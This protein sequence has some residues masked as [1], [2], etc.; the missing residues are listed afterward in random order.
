M[1]NR[2]KDKKTK[3]VLF[4][5]FCDVI[6]VDSE[7]V[8]ILRTAIETLD[9]LSK[10]FPLASE[11][12]TII[13]GV[14]DTEVNIFTIL[15]NSPPTTLVNQRNSSKLF[16]NFALQGEMK[17]VTWVKFS[18]ILGCFCWNFQVPVSFHRKG[19]RYQLLLNRIKNFT[20]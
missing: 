8:Q 10:P 19:R 18:F 13:V 12:P 16:L 14:N 5:Y 4:F 1:E 6:V 9:V 17:V 20:L 7:V 2:R 3:S 15:Y 11:L